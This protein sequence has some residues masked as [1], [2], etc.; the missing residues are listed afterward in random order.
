[1]FEHQ[2]ILIALLYYEI[3]LFNP[4]DFIAVQ[5]QSINYTGRK[6]FNIYKLSRSEHVTAAIWKIVICHF[7]PILVVWMRHSLGLVFAKKVCGGYD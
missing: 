3:F 2:V 6:T 1:M 4:E 7:L 5:L